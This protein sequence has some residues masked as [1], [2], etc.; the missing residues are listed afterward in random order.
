[1][2]NRLRI[3]LLVPWLKSKGG[4]ER[5]ILGVLKDDKYDIDVYTF[6]YGKHKTFEEFKKLKVY[7]IGRAKGGSFITKG[8]KLFYN[9]LFSPVPNLKN[10]DA[11]MVSTA[12]I[13]EF[14]VFRNRHPNTIALVHT[15]LRVAHTMYDYYRMGS[16][17]YKVLLPPLVA[18]YKFFE[19]RA[20][21]HMDYAMV[22]GQEVKRRLVDYD[23]IRS[24]RVI[25]IG[26]YVDYS[27]IKKSR[28]TE[29]IIFYGSRFISY[30]RQAMAIE[31][32]RLS[33]LPKL[34][35]KLVL[36]GFVEDPRYFDKIKTI[37]AGDKSII[38]R[39]D[40]REEE[41]R[42]IYS[43]CYCTLFLPI[44]EDTGLVP[45]ESLA[46]GKPVI[47]VNEGGPREFVRDGVNGLLINASPKSLANALDRIAGR[48]L[49]RKL[50]S[51]AAHSTVYDLDRMLSNFDEGLGV[52]LS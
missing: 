12:G 3:A 42:K 27:K 2:E 31:G 28:K 17:K 6:D 19:R 9:L 30:K 52:A 33:S 5:V 7:D 35:F 40:L 10:Y 34:G 22:L 48:R 15:P 47:A 36:G 1:M 24:N 45:I 37:A 29:K 21:K 49:Y 43:K 50:V 46:Y 51:G 20:W 39:S 32:F 8:L 41:L 16:L 25:N 26:P 4:V 44:N 18:V 14:A 13:A 23:L 38:I 11:F